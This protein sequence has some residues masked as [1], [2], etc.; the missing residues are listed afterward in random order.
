MRNTPCFSG[1]QGLKTRRLPDVQFFENVLEL[2]M[3]QGEKSC[4]EL[5]EV[6]R[7]EILKHQERRFEAFRMRNRSRT[8][9][10]ATR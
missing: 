7:K 3:A 4:V 9:A 2:K 5:S 10:C 6:A 8:R 1:A